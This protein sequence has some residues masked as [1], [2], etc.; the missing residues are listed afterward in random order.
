MILTNYVCFVEKMPVKKLKEKEETYSTA[1]INKYP[2]SKKNIM[3]LYAMTDGDT[4][5]EFFGR[6][7]IKIMRIFET[8]PDLNSSAQIF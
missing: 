6:R 1:S 7:K 8:R 3:F 2:N 4:T 5:S